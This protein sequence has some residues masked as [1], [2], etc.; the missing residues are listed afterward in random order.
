LICALI[1]TIKFRVRQTLLMFFTARR[2]TALLAAVVS[3]FFRF[4]CT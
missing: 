2:E 4:T 3:L 1:E